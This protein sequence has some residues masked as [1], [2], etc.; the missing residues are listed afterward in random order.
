MRLRP[1]LVHGLD[2]ASRSKALSSQG[3]GAFFFSRAASRPCSLHQVF[4]PPSASLF[5]SV[6]MVSLRGNLPRARVALAPSRRGVGCGAANRCRYTLAHLRSTESR[7]ELAF[8]WGSADCWFWS[9]HEL[10]G[11]SMINRT[12]IENELFSHCQSTAV[13]SARRTHA[14]GRERPW[15]AIGAVPV[16]AQ[17]GVNAFGRKNE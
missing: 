1:C 6:S 7:T 14:S 16:V 13:A 2:G 10:Q 3:P 9:V 15:A 17:R 12:V 4:L 8:A 11:M 5:S